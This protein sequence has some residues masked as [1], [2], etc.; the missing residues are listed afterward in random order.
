MQCVNSNVHLVIIPNLKKFFIDLRPTHSA[1]KYSSLKSFL[2]CLWTEMSDS[3]L[4][5]SHLDFLVEKWTKTG[6]C[7]PR[8]VV[9]LL[10][11]CSKSKVVTTT[12]GVIM[13]IEDCP[14]FSGLKVEESLRI[15][16][17]QLGKKMRQQLLVLWLLLMFTKED[18]SSS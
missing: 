12:L 7:I 9:A 18:G 5:D 13:M 16:M 2:F 3:T 17:I 1:G 11:H 10:A 8:G 4:S 6:S 15:V 14:H